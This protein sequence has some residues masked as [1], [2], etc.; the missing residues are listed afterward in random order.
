VIEQCAGRLYDFHMKDVTEATAKGGGTEVGKGVI[1][2]VGVLRTLQKIKFSGHLALEYEINEQ[3]PMPG[4]LEVL[5]LYARCDGGDL[6]TKLTQRFHI[7]PFRVDHPQFE[8][9]RNIV[10]FHARLGLAVPD[11][12]R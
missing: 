3:N 11:I 10:K 12:C 6:T 8:Q 1:D 5:C 4:V 9:G 2:I 7:D